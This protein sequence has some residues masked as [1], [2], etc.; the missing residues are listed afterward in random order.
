MSARAV[1]E[2]LRSLAA[3]HVAFQ[4]SLGPLTTYRVGGPAGVL[5]EP[6]SIE[7]LVHLRAAFDDADV[8]PDSVDVV[9]IGRGSNVVV[10]DEG[11]DG[12]VIR[13][14]QPM[15]WIRGGDDPAVVS[16]GAAT[17]LPLLANW[18]ARR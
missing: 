2:R 13:M 11:F 7:D 16:A 5:F 18:A 10:S 9:V 1:G 4:Q 15:S 6:A 14:S 3:G 12:L 17:S 8:D